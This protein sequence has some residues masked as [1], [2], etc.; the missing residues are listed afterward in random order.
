[1]MKPKS[2]AS[3]AVVAALYFVLSLVLGPL[4]NIGPSL[5]SIRVS[6]ALLLVAPA[7]VGLAPAVVGTAVGCLIWNAYSG[8]PAVDIVGGSLANALASAAAYIV[9]KSMARGRRRIGWA[10]SLAAGAAS[11]SIVTVIVGSY[12]IYLYSLP[13]ALT[14]ASLLASELV[15]IAAVGSAVLVFLEKRGMLLALTS[16]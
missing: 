12:V 8:L 5:V 6:D 13:Y 4:S 16:P 7:T 11:A 10:P 1:M 15:S 2:M 14:Y 3:S 9:L